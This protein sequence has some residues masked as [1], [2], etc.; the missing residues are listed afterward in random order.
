MQKGNY[1]TKEPELFEEVQKSEWRMFIYCFP[2]NGKSI[3]F[4]IDKLDV[5]LSQQSDMILKT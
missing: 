2:E 5:S 3:V 1:Y 4:F